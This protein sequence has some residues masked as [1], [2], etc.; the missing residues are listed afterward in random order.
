MSE[1]RD[2][3]NS[4]ICNFIFHRYW[5]VQSNS[6]E[7]LLKRMDTIEESVSST[8]YRVRINIQACLLN[9]KV[10][11]RIMLATD[12]MNINQLSGVKDGHVTVAQSDYVQI[13]GGQMVY[14]NLSGNLATS[15]SKN[16]KIL[17]KPF[18]IN[19]LDIKTYAIDEEMPKSCRVI[20]IG[21]LRKETGSQKMGNLCSLHVD[22]P[23]EVGISY[24][25]YVL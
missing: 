23:D 18:Q 15:N 24:L 9:K 22:L 20:F 21:S 17:F 14:V 12:D 10:G 8:S 25:S 16:L 4:A 7:S 1:K 6:V 19:R 11:L 2:L 3:V 5:L 13:Y